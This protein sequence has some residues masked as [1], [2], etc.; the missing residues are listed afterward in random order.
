MRPRGEGGAERGIRITLRTGDVRPAYAHDRGGDR[1]PCRASPV[2][3][4]GALSGLAAVVGGQTGPGRWRRLL[5]GT[6]A[7]GALMLYGPRRAEAACTG[8]AP[9]VTCIGNN[10]AGI[11]YNAASLVTTLNVNNLSANIT[12]ANNV[13]GI[14]LR[15]ATTATVTSTT[16]PFTVTTTGTGRGVYAR[17][18][19][20]GAVMVT[21]TGNVTADD[22]AIDAF[23][24]GGGVT[25]TSTGDL[26]SA[27]SY[28]IRVQEFGGNAVSV[29]HTGDITSDDEG[30]SVASTGGDVTVTST[31]NITSTTREG[32]Q[33]DI[34]AGAGAVM[35]SHTGN[36]TSAEEGI[37]A[38]SGGSGTVTVTS[39]GNIT[40]TTSQGIQ[41]HAVGAGAV[42]VTHTGAITANREGIFANS[43]S[44]GITVTSTGNIT[45]DREGI[46]AEENGAGAVK[47]THT[48][49]ITAA[50]HGIYAKRGTGTRS[51][52]IVSGTVTGP[53]SGVYFR[54]G[55]TN[56]LTNR[57]TVTSTGTAVLGSTGDE[58]INNFGTI[59]GTIDLGAGA[60]SIDN[61]EGGTLNTGATVVIGAGNTLTNS[62]NVSPG[63]LNAIQTTALSSN[64][65]QTEA[66]RTTVDLNVG[67]GTNDLITAT[68]ANVAG[69]FN[70]NV[71]NVAAA[72][73]QTVNVLTVTG[74]LTD[75]G[76][77]L[78]LPAALSGSVAVVG[79]NVQ[80]TYS[81]NF[82]GPANLNAGQAKTA[83]ALNS[84][85]AGGVPASFQT[86]MT[87]LANVPAAD[88]G[89]ALDQVAGDAY[90]NT[91]LGSLLANLGNTN[92][93]FSCPVLGGALA[94]IRE[95]ECVWLRPQGRFYRQ[96]S[97]ANG[98]G[99]H[100]GRLRDFRRPAV[101]AQQ[102][103][104]LA[105][106]LCARLRERQ[107]E[108]PDGPGQDRDRP[109]PPRPG[110]QAP[111]R[112]DAPVGRGQWRLCPR[113]QPAH[114]LDPGLRRNGDLRLQPG[115][116]HRAVPG[117]APVRPGPVVSQADARPRPHLAAPLGLHRDRRR[118]GQ[119]RGRLGERAQLQRLA[120]T[121]D[122]R[123]VQAGKGAGG[124]A[125][126]TRGPHRLR[127]RPE[128]DDRQL[129][130]RA[131][132]HTQLHHHQLVRPA[133][134]HRGG[135]RHPAAGRRERGEEGRDDR[136]R[137]V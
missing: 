57:G 86:M 10:A 137:G 112:R 25:L 129:R 36:V 2:A 131:G 16:T 52:T 9:T 109:L 116:R 45:S 62:G 24:W 32:I 128:L 84:I 92:N 19:G 13:H 94:Y 83:A 34:I 54:E 75:S 29:T 41:A 58:T 117:R 63:G 77:T 3:R 120:R 82:A 53:T 30:L 135:R 70:V 81:V 21:H 106:R 97:S 136:A 6:A 43:N 4:A 111:D 50:T 40:S 64:F 56:T 51:V 80:I 107:G 72:T 105:R 65:T 59:T 74:T 17:S 12:P 127:R 44:G 95:G 124:A 121:G 7:A 22:H 14:Y 68:D 134:R 91:N 11:S 108:Q 73:N 101:R 90:L 60:N 130:Q 28:G 61:M 123:P 71:V 35:V 99:L 8:A 132:R 20:A 89:A 5:F 103:Q 110:G 104:D 33:V 48:G 79:K 46:E 76:P 125:L 23:S 42:K 69:S 27:S 38:V 96:N 100:R 18:N 115:L 49:D 93:L 102:G 87:A 31:G 85:L 55:T 98:P 88:Y 15:S 118:G 26:T 67:A 114:G 47:V 119:P 78:V 126:P 122:R 113:R 1:A 66:G 37:R 39:T 133:L